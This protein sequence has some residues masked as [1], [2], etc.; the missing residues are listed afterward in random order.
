MTSEEAYAEKRYIHRMER[1]QLQ[2]GKYKTKLETKVETDESTGK[3]VEKNVPVIDLGEDGQ[4]LHLDND[5][6][7]YGI[8]WLSGDRLGLR[9]RRWTEIRQREHWRY[10]RKSQYRAAKRMPSPPKKKVRQ[11][12]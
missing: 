1:D 3:S 8:K 10:H 7:T 12:S 5:L 9:K 4:A 2:N 6:R 11:T